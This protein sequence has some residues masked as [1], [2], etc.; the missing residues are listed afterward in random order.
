MPDFYVYKKGEF[1]PAQLARLDVYPDDVRRAADYKYP[2]ARVQI[3]EGL[4]CA[5][6]KWS[7]YHRWMNGKELVKRCGIVPGVCAAVCEYDRTPPPPAKQEQRANVDAIREYAE[8]V[9]VA[10]GVNE[11]DAR[12]MSFEMLVRLAA[13]ARLR[14]IPLAEFIALNQNDETGCEEGDL[15][16]FDS[17]CDRMNASVAAGLGFPA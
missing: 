5:I 7:G 10:V 12:A 15:K 3:G 8:T 13:I 4:C 11:T 2:Y 16:D 17:W 6:V 14:V 9:A 1:D